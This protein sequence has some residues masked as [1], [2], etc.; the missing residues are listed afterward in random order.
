MPAVS[1]TEWQTLSSEDV[2]ASAGDITL[3]RHGRSVAKALGDKNFVLI[4]ELRTGIALKTTSYV[5]RVNVGELELRIRPKINGLPLLELFHYG[6]ELRNVHLFPE[7]ALEHAPDAIQ[8]IL[9][10]QLVEE[11]KAI[12]RRGA[13]QEYVREQQDR[14]V[15]RGKPDLQRWFRSASEVSA[16]MPCILTPR[17][18]DNSLNP[19]FQ[20]SK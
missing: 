20:R 12:F 2:A 13:H 7:H 16:V 19:E 18:P 3:D 8:D 14:A 17:S 1:L 11:V 10:L 6:Y 4:E 5:G 9:I 15:L